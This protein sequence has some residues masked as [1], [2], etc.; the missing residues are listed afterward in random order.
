MHSKQP[1]ASNGIEAKDHGGGEGALK[2]DALPNRSG[3]AALTPCQTQG[4]S[5]GDL[6]KTHIDF[7]DDELTIGCIAGGEDWRID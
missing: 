7:L 1:R 5:A 2:R 4:F 3:E 6:C